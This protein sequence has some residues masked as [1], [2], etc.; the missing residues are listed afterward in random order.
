MTTKDNK[1]KEEKTVAKSEKIYN[2]PVIVLIN[3]NTASASE[4][5][6]GALK[7]NEIATVIGTTSYGKGV[8]QTVITL[9]DG[10]GLK[11]TSAE[12]FTPTGA[13]INK[14]GIEPNI[15]SKL[16]STIK[17]IYSI[18]EDDDTQLKKAI[19]ELKK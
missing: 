13:Q 12:Y 15:E 16:P 6:T 3:E 10:S 4:I 17:S 14:K 18:K 7:D 11:I 19:E 9:A 5:L 8:I 2:V 1:Q